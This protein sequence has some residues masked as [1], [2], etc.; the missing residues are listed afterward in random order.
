MK[1]VLIVGGSGFIGTHLTTRL[2]AL[3]H[4]VA[5]FD[6]A[7]SA[8]HPQLVTIGDVREARA[9]AAAAAGRDCIVNLAAEHRDDVRPVSRYFEVN[10]GGA[11]NLVAAAVESKVP[12]LIFLSTVAVYGLD[13]PCA[14]E[15][16]PIKPFNA[17]AHSKAESEKVY[18][19]WAAAAPGRS[20]LVLRPAVVFGEGNRGNVYTLI[21]QLRRHRL[22][23]IG[24]GR[25]FKS[26]AYVGNIVEF[27]SQRVEATPGCE[28][29]NYSDPP[30]MTMRDFVASIC[31][32]LQQ[33]APTRSIPYWLGL[34]AG[35]AGDALALLLRRP[36]AVSSVRVRKFCATT[37]VSSARLDASGFARPFSL[38]QGLARMI[39]AM[40]AC[41][42]KDIA[43][44]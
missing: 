29:F 10:V 22:L 21:E 35:Y 20:L 11:R 16:A 31:A 2:L 1:R 3:G 34:A 32:L 40:V 15:S 26:M 7:P 5:I 17:Y 12:R 44:P 42:S 19:S 6:K 23:M 37:Q 18:S 8:T 9:L 33:P 14:D 25:N 30:D 38:N 28:L 24:A 13:Q 39:A 41:E 43:S 27:I 36:F 4:H